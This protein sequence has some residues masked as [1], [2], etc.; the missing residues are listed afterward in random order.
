MV[1][2]HMKRCLTSLIIKKNTNQDTRRYYLIPTRMAIIKTSAIYKCW[3]GCG[4][5]GTLLTVLVGIKI[6]TT[7]VE[8]TMIVSQKSKNRIII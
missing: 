6:A 3:R 7:T 1:K 4:E 8:N 2:K 5:M